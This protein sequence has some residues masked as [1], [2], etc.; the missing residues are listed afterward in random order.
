MK[1][2]LSY[3]LSILVCSV[4]LTAPAHAATANFG[5]N[6]S[7]NAD[8][9]H[10]DCFFDGL[11]GDNLGNPGS[12]CANTSNSPQ[13]Y[14]DYGDFTSSPGFSYNNF[15]SHQYP[16]PIPS[17]TRGYP[18]GYYVNLVVSCPGEAWAQATRYICV[19][20]FGFPGCISPGSGWN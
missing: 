13:Y 18:Y 14:W 20:G 12:S 2:W 11:R 15:T 16:L 8:G 5:G 10:L 6:C 1:R 19:Y 4:V 3:G 7:F 17:G 9:V